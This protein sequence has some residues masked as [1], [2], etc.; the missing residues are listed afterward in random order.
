MHEVIKSIRN[1]LL[2]RVIVNSCEKEMIIERRQVQE[3][4]WKGIL[5]WLGKASWRAS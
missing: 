3:I 5:P 2:N 1:N 4:S